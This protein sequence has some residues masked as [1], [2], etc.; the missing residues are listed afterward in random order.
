MNLTILP[1][2]GTEYICK[3][4]ARSMSYDLLTLGDVNV[5]HLATLSA[6]FWSL[7]CPILYNL[8]AHKHN[9]LLSRVSGPRT[10]A[11][12]LTASTNTLIP[13]SPPPN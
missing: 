5:V 1:T 7:L 9:E 8:G 4:D 6:S 2:S 10:Y 13:S 11:C 3:N 12:P